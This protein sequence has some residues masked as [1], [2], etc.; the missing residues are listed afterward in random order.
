MN[1]LGHRPTRGGEN[2][3]KED[4]RRGKW[5]L[6][7]KEQ[8]ISGVSPPQHNIILAWDCLLLPGCQGWRAFFLF[9]KIPFMHFLC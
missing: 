9:P 3:P 5:M 1:N 4:R 8:N 6:G 7:A 2:I